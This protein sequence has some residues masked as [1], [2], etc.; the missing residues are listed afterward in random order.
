MQGD[1]KNHYSLEGMNLY[2][3]KIYDGD[4]NLKET[5]SAEKLKERVWKFEK[6]SSR[7]AKYKTPA[8]RFCEQCGKPFEIKVKNQ[9]FCKGEGLKRN[10]CYQK[11]YR[12][13][14]KVEQYEKECE[15]CGKIFKGNL[16][17][18]FCNDPCYGDV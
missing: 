2:E 13:G 16:A 6:P 11:Y 9:R 10:E 7:N 18:R 4:G 17:R 14:L 15:K 5:V 12:E 3:V 1:R 8:T